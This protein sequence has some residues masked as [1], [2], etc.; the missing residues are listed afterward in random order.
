[1]IQP[2]VP[3]EDLVRKLPLPLAQLYRRAHDAKTPL[4][5]HLA[6][7]YLWEASLK[8]L[9][10]VAIVTYAEAGEPA[11][12]LAERLQ[13]LARPALGHWW[14]FIRL[15][16][17]VLADSGDEG[18]RATRDLVLGQSRDDLPRAAGLDAALREELD[19]AGGA[20]VTVR[21]S[22]LFDRLVRYRNREIGHG[23]TGQRPF[24]FYE[25]MGRTLLL[26][27]SELLGR[28]DILAGRRLIAV[29]DVRRLGSGDW[30]VE[31]YELA[32]RDPRPLESLETPESDAHGLPRPGCLYLEAA[33]AALVS[34]HSRPLHPLVLYDH[35]T[36]EV[37]F[38]SARRGRKRVEYLC[39]NSGRSTERDD[40]GTERRALLARILGGRVDDEQID[41]WATASAAEEPVVPDS[42]RLQ[43]RRMGEFELRSELGRGGMG[44][45]YRAWQ[46]SLGRE[47]ALKCLLRAGD[48]KAEA[49]FNREIHALGRVEHPHLVKVFT[50]GSEGDQWFYAME[51][52]E[53]A[54]LGAVCGRLQGRGSTVSELD[55]ETWRESLSTACQDARAAERPL[56]ADEPGAPRPGR[57]HAVNLPY[58]SS[59]GRDYLRHVVELILQVAEASHSL[60]E[61]DVIHRDIKP[62]NILV[63]PDGA[64]A[65]LMDLGLAQLADEAEGRLTRTR[66][67]V[68]TLRYASPEQVLSIPLDRRSDIYSLGAT[69]WELLTLRP[70]FG[71][72]DQMPTPDLMLKI[73]H[74]DPDR[75]RHLNP[76]VPEDLEAIVLKCLEKDR[77][78]RYGT[79]RELADDLSR[80]LRGEPVQAQPPTLRYLLGKSVRRHRVA[81]ALASTIALTAVLGT[82]AA[83]ATSTALRIDRARREAELQRDRAD[84]AAAG[85]KVASAK[86]A[87]AR[88]TAEALKEELRLRLVKIDVANGLKV[89][90]ESDFFGSLAWFAD[91][92]RLEQRD[93]D[94]EA[95]ART[96]LIATLSHCP[97]LTQ[98]VFH[99]NTVAHAELS[100]DGRRLVTASFDKTARVWDADT[101][102]P[103][104]PPL[105]HESLVI[106]A[107]FSPDG[108]R[109]VTASVDQAA[110]VWDAISGQPV[111]P[112]L[113]HGW[114]VRHAIFS[115]DGR[116]VLTASQDS[117][118]RVW[119]ADTG[120]PVPI[121]A[122]QHVYSL[123]SPVFSPDGMRRVVRSAADNTAQVCD[124][125]RGQPIAPPLKHEATINHAIFSPDGRRV[126][127]SSEDKTARVWDAISG[128]PITPALK[129]SSGVRRAS[130]SPD[131]RRVVTISADHTARVWDAISGQPVTPLLKHGHD[132]TGAAFSSDGRR[133]VTA[134][135]DGTARVWDAIPEHVISS[136][137]EHGDGL[138]HASFSADGRRVLTASYDNTARVWDSSPGEP[139]SP[140]LDYDGWELTKAFS[141]DGQRLVIA[142]FDGTT[143]V[144][145]AKSRQPVS[146]PLKHERW[147]TTAS[148]SLDGRRVLTGSDDKT[149]RVWDASTGQPISPALK[150]G[151]R[152]NCASFSPDG[153]RVLTA[154]R[155]LDERM[156]GIAQVWDASSGQ[157]ISPPMKHSRVVNHAAFSPDG[158][159]VLTACADATARVWDAASGQPISPPMSHISAVNYAAFSRD[160][161]LI[162]TAS[163]DSRAQVWEAASGQP[164]SPPLKHQSSVNHATFSP[165][166]LRVVTA[167]NDCTA[168]VWKS[169]SVQPTSPLLTCPASDLISVA[170]LLSMA[171]VDGSGDLIPLD[172]QEYRA[173][174]LR[175]RQRFP[176]VFGSSPEEILAWHRSEAAGCE[177]DGAWP[178]AIQHL[179][180]LIQ[181]DP[182]QWRVHSRRGRANARLGRWNEAIAD[183]SRAIAM[184]P[185]LDAI[186]KYEQ[187][188]NLRADVY[189]RMGRWN[190][191]AGDFSKACELD[192]G[193]AVARIGL[194]L[195]SIA[196]N[197]VKS[198]RDSCARLL[199]DFS[200]AHDPEVAFELARTCLAAPI[201]AKDAEVALRLAQRAPNKDAEVSLGLRQRATNASGLTGAALFRAGKLKDATA[202][203]TT[204]LEPE[205]A[206]NGPLPENASKKPAQVDPLVIEGVDATILLFLAMAHQQL[207]H[208]EESRSWLRKGIASIDQAIKGPAEDNPRHRYL[209]WKVKLT[210]NLLRHEAESMINGEKLPSK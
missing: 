105:K 42:E 5:R 74:A 64:Q 149:A 47:V 167:S 21:L 59:A 3:D 69:L 147:V 123:A 181:A 122:E 90:D 108:Q 194:A 112:P 43:R 143:R 162:V 182:G 66:Q 197:D 27:T 44:V 141:P 109:V 86:E 183:Y 135:A 10:S 168:R 41:R 126:V 204:A 91:A 14:A 187:P 20:R 156:S 114:I 63:T 30:L 22:E 207:G 196:N 7:F 130:F 71:A 35:A 163:A 81:I 151:Y 17:P 38:L 76:R 45:V 164:I 203:L 174:W 99:D 138:W 50:S 11:P 117:T 9:A 19:G 61:S 145:D 2:F 190:Q 173:R 106:D 148:F 75:P 179:D 24:D 100:P 129:H 208:A 113:K 82:V 49:R 72:T 83:I 98:V 96:R 104:S 46:P 56:S 93:P 152:V 57:T 127:T 25:R 88:R 186:W 32:G 171:Q 166:G 118:T 115:P 139:I 133:V 95:A 26:G 107:S 201:T 142:G 110:R 33:D 177:Q 120:Q 55:L 54:T 78:R 101:G 191:A 200:R 132:V 165:D 103:V 134:S 84:K 28:L 176:E 189:A 70:L 192:S 184:R 13:N 6:A 80:W 8:L 65:V 51:L 137:L 169:G 161:R 94:R 62:D 155:V 206:N 12:E 31:R 29:T 193:D 119:D 89:M 136:P 160:G 210:L 85:E 87:E 205:I 116:R 16:V 157:P 18:F 159:H 52:V 36:A 73:Q 175:L 40:L 202:S 97:R 199:K 185:E 67:F 150:H 39:Y 37:F 209:D 111:T 178:S 153:R 188:L 60:H 58:S 172:P 158:R 23:A 195:T 79:A 131:G 128:Q 102:Q 170:Q 124:A 48:P 1:M 92:V 53:G 144:L 125:G 198:F 4:D 154:S 68:G 140:P 34:L 121:L 180:A 15:V 146:P 77:G